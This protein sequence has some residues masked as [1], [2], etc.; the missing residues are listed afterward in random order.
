MARA[1][2]MHVRQSRNVAGAAGGALAVALAL[3]AVLVRA[4][5]PSAL[6]RHLHRV[7][8]A[9]IGGGRRDGGNAPRFAAA[10]VAVWQARG[11]GEEEPP[12]NE[13]AAAKRPR[14]GADCASDA[15]AAGAAD[16]EAEG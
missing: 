2:L 7:A 14:V 3:A 15:A 10:A 9:A 8:M 5:H 11:V 13:K 1:A 12:A 4:R 6:W 16:T